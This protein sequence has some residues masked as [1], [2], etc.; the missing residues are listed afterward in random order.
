MLENILIDYFNLPEDYED[1]E[2]NKSYD[3]L[4]NLLYDLE[5]LGVLDNAN[6]VIDELDKIDNENLSYVE[7]DSKLPWERY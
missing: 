3:K 7:E 4:I 2:W 1:Y 6:S 5:K